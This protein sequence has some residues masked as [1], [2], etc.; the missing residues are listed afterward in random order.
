MKTTTRPAA[1]LVAAVLMAGIIAVAPVLARQAERTRGIQVKYDKGE[2][3]GVR[4][5]VLKGESG[6]WIPVDPSRQ[7]RENDEIKIAFESN[8]SGYVYILNV[9][10]KGKKVVLFPRLDMKDNR[11]VPLQRYELPTRGAMVFDKETGVEILQVVMSPDPIQVYDDAVRNS[12]GELGASASSAA[13]E[14]TAN[15]R[16]RGG[17]FS[18]NV[19]VAAPPKGVRTR[20]LELAPGKDKDAK[21]TILIAN[22]EGGKGKLVKGEIAVF[23]LRLQHI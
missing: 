17:I 8:F 12:E 11:L 20:G 6:K 1:R 15:S 9:T 18:E 3:D 2:V 21:G 5:L 14:L 22:P 4:I 19:A 23:E 16:K 10:P 7:F 13:A